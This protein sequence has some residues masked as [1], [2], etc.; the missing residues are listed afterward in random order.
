MIKITDNAKECIWAFVMFF[1][2]V[3]GII[4]GSAA[5]NLASM[6]K[7]FL[8]ALAG[9][10]AFANTGYVVYDIYKNHVKPKD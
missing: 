4:A 10:V 7:N 9:I 5:L 8:Y 6:E 1:L 2:G 3:L